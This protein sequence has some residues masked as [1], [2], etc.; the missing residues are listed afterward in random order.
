MGLINEMTIDINGGIEI[1]ENYSGYTYTKNN[2]TLTCNDTI[3]SININIKNGVY[4]VPYVNTNPNHFIDEYDID[5]VMVITGDTFEQWFEDY[6]NSIAT[7]E[8]SSYD[9]STIENRLL[10]EKSTG[11]IYKIE[12]SFILTNDTEPVWVIYDN[13]NDKIWSPTDGDYYFYE[14]DDCLNTTNKKL[15]ALIDINKH[16]ETNLTIKYVEMCE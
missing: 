9:G 11:M 10:Y 14:Q 2:S 13:M 12:H 16:S 7:S 8:Y 4:V 5:S 1:K 6:I 15:V 3:N